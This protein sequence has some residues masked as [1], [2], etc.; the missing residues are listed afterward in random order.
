MVQIDKMTYI[1]AYLFKFDDLGVDF[2]QTKCHKW[3][4][5]IFQLFRSL[6][7]RSRPY[8]GSNKV[9]KNIKCGTWIFTQ[10]KQN[11]FNPFMSNMKGTPVMD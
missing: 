7:R 3:I 1:W 5:A 11:L 4:Y 10:A 8:N 6:G 9:K 2:Y